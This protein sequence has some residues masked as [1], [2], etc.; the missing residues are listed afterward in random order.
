VPQQLADGF[1]AES[2]LLV[3][4]VGQEEVLVFLRQRVGVEVAQ[5]AEAVELVLDL[6]LEG[7]ALGAGVDGRAVRRPV[8]RTFS[9]YSVLKRIGDRLGVD[10]INVLHA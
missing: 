4:A 3:E 6:A 10:F 1:L 9:L 5:F 8:A 2:L 7:D